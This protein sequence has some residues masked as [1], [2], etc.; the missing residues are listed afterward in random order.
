MFLGHASLLYQV[1]FS[2]PEYRLFILCFVH[3][4]WVLIIAWR[5]YS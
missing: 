5:D 2:L 4:A 3:W 1:L